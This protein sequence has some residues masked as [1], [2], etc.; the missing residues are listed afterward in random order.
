MWIYEFFRTALNPVV[1]FGASSTL[2]GVEYLIFFCGFLAAGWVLNRTFWKYF[3]GQEKIIYPL[4]TYFL[5]FGWF[6]NT[7]IWTEVFY[8]FCGTAYMWAMSFGMLTVALELIYFTK[9][10][11]KVTIWLSVIGALSCSFYSQAV[12]PCMMFL[13]LM[14]REILNEK[15]I[16]WRRCIP[17]GCFLLGALSAMAAPGNF[18]RKGVED[19]V[20]MSLTGAFK[21]A[22]VMWKDSFLELIKNPIMLIVMIAFIVIGMFGLKQSKYKF[23]YPFVP[24]VIALVTLYVTYF[25]FALGYGGSFYLPNR[26]VFVYNMFA[27]MLFAASSIYLGG[28]LRYKQGI[29]LTKKD[30]LG[31]AV[32]IV[33]FAY[34]W[35]VPTGSYWNVPY[36]QTV[37]LMDDVADANEQWRE[38]LKEIETAK[39]ENVVVEH[40]YIDTPIIKWPGL[41]S[42]VED[43][44]NK[45]FASYYGKES[46]QLIWK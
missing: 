29:T 6:L 19:E 27:V 34:V 3:I 32:G 9:P 25:P 23:R 5:M 24:F 22:A 26:A 17:F 28:W 37:G 15:K 35:Y 14:A 36:L 30:I 16:N 40:T 7:K 4:M 13:L 20:K 41:T 1:L 44:N 45:K 10:T 31:G 8:W 11:K 38:V 21:D 18:S 33:L 2:A 12:F 46:V 39:G 43:A 42:N